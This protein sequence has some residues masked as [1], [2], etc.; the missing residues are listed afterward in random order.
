MITRIGLQ[1]LKISDRFPFV[2]VRE[3]EGKQVFMN[4]GASG[5]THINVEEDLSLVQCL[6]NE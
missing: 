3:V 1:R 6:G 5:L 2:I 4:R